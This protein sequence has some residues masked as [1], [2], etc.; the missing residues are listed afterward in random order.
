VMTGRQTEEEIGCC[1]KQI[2]AGVRY[3]HE[4]GL[5]HRDLKLD[6]C[7][8]NEFGIVKIID[9]GCAV[10]FKYPLEQDLIE[11]TGIISL[12]EI[13]T[14]GI[15]GSDPYLAPEVCTE[16][17]YDPQPADIWSLAIIF[18]YLLCF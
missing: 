4:M 14:A 18:W 7:V 2:V 12:I 3:L 11:A 8:V 6:N 16:I 13:L 9:F 15:V 1:F 10:V 5:A 17:R